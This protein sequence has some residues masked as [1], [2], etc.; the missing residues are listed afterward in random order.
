MN[1]TALQ[2]F[3]DHAAVDA[4]AGVNRYLDGITSEAMRCADRVVKI[5][6]DMRRQRERF[7]LRVDPLPY[8]NNQR[9]WLCQNKRRVIEI[10]DRIIR[11]ATPR[12]PEEIA[13]MWP[14]STGAFHERLC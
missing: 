2:L 6:D 4:A 8:R 7:H 13:R 14:T 1:Q 3:I 9:Y 12:S 10:A 5:R 11:N